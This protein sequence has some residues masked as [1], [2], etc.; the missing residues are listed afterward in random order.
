MSDTND[1]K[2]LDDAR[3][4]INRIDSEMARLFLRRMRAVALVAEYKRAEG[5]AVYDP[6]RERQVIERN[7]ALVPED[8]REYYAA[9]QNGVMSVS[10]MYQERLLSAGK[11][12]K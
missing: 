5:V 4:E 10:R 8:M 7:S 3:E 11:A 1:K 12:D 6:E 2:L 9:Y